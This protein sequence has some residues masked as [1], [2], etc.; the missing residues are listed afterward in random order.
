MGQGRWLI[1]IAGIFFRSIVGFL[2]D[3][4]PILYDVVFRE[5]RI[6]ISKSNVKR[7]IIDF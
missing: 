7:F 3:Q 6:D 2:L 4:Y 5:G 1:A